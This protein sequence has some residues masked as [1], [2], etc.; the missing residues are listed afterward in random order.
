IKACHIGM[1]S[2]T[3]NAKPGPLHT[4]AERGWGKQDK[5]AWGVER[6]PVLPKDPTRKAPHVGRP[7]NELSP[8][9][10]DPP[11]LR[12]MRQRIRH[13]FNHV[14]HGHDRKHALGESNL[15]Q[16]AYLDG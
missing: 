9:R 1:T 7:N 12:E 11:A 14:A 13:M 16:H 10:E 2:L 5:V 8:R 6:H 15:R 3:N 4:G